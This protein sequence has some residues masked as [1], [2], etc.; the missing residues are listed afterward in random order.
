MLR[1]GLLLLALLASL[2]ASPLDVYD[3]MKPVPLCRALESLQVGDEIPVVLSGVYSVD[4]LFD[5]GDLRCQLNVK[6]MTCVEFAPDVVL[7]DGFKAL[8]NQWGTYEGVAVTFRGIL[9]GPPKTPFPP[10]DP[11]V[12]IPHRALLRNSL[13]KLYCGNQYG[14]KFVVHSVESFGPVPDGTAWPG[15]RERP[16][17]EQPVPVEMALP[18]YP[19]IARKIDYEGMVLVAVTVVAGEV[20][21]AQ[22]QFGDAVLVNEALANVETWRFAPDVSASFTVEYDFRLEKRAVSQGRNP[23]FEMRPPT[24]IGVIGVVEDY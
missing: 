4:Y 12:P 24:Y 22:I 14:T 2:P 18:E 11:S 6:P 5:P 3:D 9:Y 8:Q 16:E 1:I 21:D 7:P 15:E 23:R 19:P 17:D 13:R 20:T 10:F